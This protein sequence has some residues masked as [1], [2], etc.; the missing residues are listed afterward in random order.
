[1]RTI[2]K[3]ILWIDN[4]PNIFG[5][6]L[7]FLCFCALISCATLHPDFLQPTTTWGLAKQL[8]LAIMSVPFLAVAFV[9]VLG[10]LLWTIGE[11]INAIISFLAWLWDSL[12]SW[13]YKD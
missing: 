11:I 4:H 10:I 2:K 13:A 3:L 12:L 9:A 1:M 7:S 8:I 5:L 6:C